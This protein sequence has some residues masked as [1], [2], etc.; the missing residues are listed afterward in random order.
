[1]RPE[2]TRL[3]WIEQYLL[4]SPAPAATAAWQLQR[5]L[6]PELAADAAAQQQVYAGLRAAGRQQ[7]RRE[8]RTL[9]AQL[10]GPRRSVATRL[11]NGWAAARAWWLG[12]SWQ[13]SR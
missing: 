9:H 8:L 11:A 2:L 1:M 3:H 5:V 10:Y 12:A 7:L 4:G 6:D 13:R